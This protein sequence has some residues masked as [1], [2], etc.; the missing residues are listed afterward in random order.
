[1]TPRSKDFN[2]SKDNGIPSS[3]VY[4]PDLSIIQSHSYRKVHCG[5]GYGKRRALTIQSNTKVPGPGTYKIPSCFD[6]YKSHKKGKLFLI[7]RQV[8]RRRRKKQKKKLDKKL[9]RETCGFKE[10]TEE[11]ENRD[12]NYS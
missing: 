12:S 7:N 5:L 11:K 9:L 8:L 10:T 4:L 6:K 3:G 2:I 1:M